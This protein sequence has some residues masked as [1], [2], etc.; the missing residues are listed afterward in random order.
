MTT[1]SKDICYPFI[2]ATVTKDNIPYRSASETLQDPDPFIQEFNE[3]ITLMRYNEPHA[4]G[5][6]LAI[7]VGLDCVRTQRCDIGYPELLQNFRSGFLAA[8]KTLKARKTLAALST[9]NRETPKHFL[10]R[11]RLAAT[12]T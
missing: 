9:E 1:P 2:L 5:L 3:Y 11:A 4:L 12:L 7:Q 8:D 6:K 10:D